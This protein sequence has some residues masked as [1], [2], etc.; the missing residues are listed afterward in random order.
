MSLYSYSVVIP[1]FEADDRLLKAVNSVTNQTIKPDKIF[2]VDDCSVLHTVSEVIRGTS[3][4]SSPLIEI[5]VNKVNKGPG[6]SRNRAI[7]RVTSTFTA[8]L[9]AD[10][11]WYGKKMEHQLKFLQNKH[12]AAV[13]CLVEGENRFK[14]QDN[15]AK[16]IDF[17]QQIFRHHIT[18]STLVCHT[19]VVKEMGGFNETYR[20]AE[21]GELLLKLALR[22]KLWLI[23][24]PLVKYADGCTLNQSSGLSSSRWSMSFGNLYALYRLVKEK[25][26]GISNGLFWS[27][28]VI[29]K[30]VY[31]ELKIFLRVFNHS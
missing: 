17:T 10:D 9:D 12:S 31:R 3:L 21:E 19:T 15:I 5:L 7:N 1:C 29:I 4:E 23:T 11:I 25:E 30:Y 26:I 28:W 22:N 16:K 8:F 13:G 14:Y 18:P 24:T 2:I 27:I 20:F 6:F